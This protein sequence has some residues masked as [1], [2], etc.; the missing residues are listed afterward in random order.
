MTS[1][2]NTLRQYSCCRETHKRSCV[3]SSDSWYR[4]LTACWHQQFELL[5]QVAPGSMCESNSTCCTVLDVGTKNVYSTIEIRTM[6][7]L[8][9]TMEKEMVIRVKVWTP[10]TPVILCSFTLQCGLQV[11]LC[12]VLC[13]FQWFDTEATLC[14]G[15]KTTWSSLVHSLLTR[16]FSSSRS[17]IHVLYT[18]SCINPTRCNQLDSN[19]AN[20]EATVEMG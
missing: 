12:M 19:V 8:G 3:N 9:F 14:P 6:L 5:K 4:Q 2:I 17:V 18:F 10:Q 20:L 15:K 16:C 13:L 11:R 7:L 1:R